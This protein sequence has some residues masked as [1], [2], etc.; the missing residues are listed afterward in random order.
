LSF[1]KSN[2]AQGQH[3]NNAYD[4]DVFHLKSHKTEPFVNK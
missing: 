1:N 3:F 2:K 4:Y